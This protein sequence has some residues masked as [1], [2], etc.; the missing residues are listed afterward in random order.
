M[1]LE[2]TSKSSVP[3]KK[4]MAILPIAMITATAH[5]IF[6]NILLFFMALFVSLGEIKTYVHV[7]VGIG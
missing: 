3:S 4:E 2:H 1:P 5:H 6:E 7:G